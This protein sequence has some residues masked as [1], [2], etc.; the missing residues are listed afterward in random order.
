MSL[1]LQDELKR[2]LEAIYNEAGGRFRPDEAVIAAIPPG[3]FVESAHSYGHS[4]WSF[5][6]MINAENENG[7]PKPFFLKVRR[8]FV[9]KPEDLQPYLPIAWGKLRESNPEAYFFLIEFKTFGPGLPNPAKLGARVAE[10]HKKSTS[11]TNMFGFHTVTYDGARP[12]ALG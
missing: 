11:P 6:A 1:E 9:R 2:N 12:Q 7:D 10:M 4:A 3:I 8:E 5:T